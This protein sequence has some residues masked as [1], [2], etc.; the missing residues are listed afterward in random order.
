MRPEVGDCPFFRYWITVC[1]CFSA[2]VVVSVADPGSHA[3]E[4]NARYATLTLLPLHGFTDVEQ[5]GARSL[6]DLTTLSTYY[7]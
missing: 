7:K 6:H 1:C 4:E 3:G 5:N 2:V